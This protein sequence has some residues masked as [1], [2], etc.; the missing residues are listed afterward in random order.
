MT[1]QILL[2]DRIILDDAVYPRTMTNWLTTLDYAESL[3]AGAK[4]PPIT[5]CQRGKKYILID[6][7]H[8]IAALKKNGETHV[9]SII[10]K[11]L[12]NKEIYV[13]AVKRNIGNGRQLSPYEKRIVAVKLQDLNIDPIEISKIL[14]IRVEN[15]KKF[16]ASKLTNTLTGK[17]IVL[18]SSVSN[19]NNSTVPENFEEIQNNLSVPSQVNL[20]NQLLI[21][22]ENDLLDLENGE[23][24]RRL[25]EIH[26]YLQQM[27]L[28]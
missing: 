6:G 28:T 21:L 13:E 11:G 8:T 9:S 17:P 7:R 1:Q 24:T 22:L 12:S 25:G 15:I 2:I 23:I 26:D 4:F 18:K 14:C 10:L 27:Q 19:M 16:V 20:L 3:L 5:V